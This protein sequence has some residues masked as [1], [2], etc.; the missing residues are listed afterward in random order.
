[1]AQRSAQTAALS[2]LREIVCRS[3]APIRH[4][5]A[6]IDTAPSPA[7]RNAAPTDVGSAPAD[8]ASDGNSGSA[9]ATATA[10]TP[11]G[12]ASIPAAANPVPAAAKVGDTTTTNNVDG[13]DAVAFSQWSA[14]R[15]ALLQRTPLLAGLVRCLVGGSAAATTT[16]IAAPS[17][18]HRC[19]VDGDRDAGEGKGAAAAVRVLHEACAT[20]RCLL[21]SEVGDC[22]LGE[23][24][25]GERSEIPQAVFRA[26]E[27]VLWRGSGS[28]EEGGGVAVE[29]GGDGGG[30]GE[31]V[32]LCARLVGM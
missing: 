14:T 2:L 27:G 31:A 10:A 12:G 1:M 25:G 6:P 16:V 26:L 8:S 18:L 17:V 7:E 22:L 29:P 9:A 13:A 19:G 21:S 4:P 20:M 3:S 24:G 15:R 30:C 32:R 5:G 23:G 28:S 11:S